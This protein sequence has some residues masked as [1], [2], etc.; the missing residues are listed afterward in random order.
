MKNVSTPAVSRRK[1]LA[2]TGAAG[3]TVAL[4]AALTG[5]SGS[6]EP[7]SDSEGSAAEIDY[8]NWDAVLEAAKGQTVSWYGYGGSEP[9]NEWIESVL[10]PLTEEG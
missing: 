8:T 6:S 5:C 10:T 3:A 2:L 7:A 9:R 4:G 1:F